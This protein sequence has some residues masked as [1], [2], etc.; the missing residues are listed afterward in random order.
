MRPPTPKPSHPRSRNPTTQK[1]RQMHR[2]RERQQRGLRR[3][4]ER[5]GQG[6]LRQER[7]P[8]RQAVPSSRRRGAQPEPGPGTAPLARASRQVPGSGQGPGTARAGSARRLPRRTKASTDKPGGRRGGGARCASGSF[9]VCCG[10]DQE[11]RAK[12]RGRKF[13]HPSQGDRTIRHT[14]PN[15]PFPKGFFRRFGRRRRPSRGRISGQAPSRFRPKCARRGF[16]RDRLA[17][18]CGRRAVLAP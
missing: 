17:L 18:L 9:R 10:E 4:Q 12:G 1:R 6:R 2:R 13:Y 5:P 11:P 14:F 15:W 3:R 16:R 8:G 7:E